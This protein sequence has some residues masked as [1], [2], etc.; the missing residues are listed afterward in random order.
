MMLKTNRDGNDVLHVYNLYFPDKNSVGGD[1]TRL[2]LTATLTKLI[3]RRHSKMAAPRTV[4]SI[5]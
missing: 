1:R 4:E 3:L 5:A 2:I